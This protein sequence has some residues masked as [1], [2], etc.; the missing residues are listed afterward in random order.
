MLN[1]YSKTLWGRA[2]WW[3]KNWLSNFVSP[4]NWQ[5]VTLK[6]FWEH[7]Y[8]LDAESRELHRE[9]LELE[10]AIQNAKTTK[11]HLLYAQLAQNAADVRKRVQAEEHE[12]FSNLAIN[13]L[14]GEFD[15]E[16]FYIQSKD[17]RR[18]NAIDNY[19]R[20]IA[21]RVFSAFN[22]CCVFCR[23]TDDLTFDHYALSKNEGGNFVLIS[24]DKGSIRLNIVV[25]CRGCNAAKAQHGHLFYFNDEQRARAVSCQR[26]LLDILLGDEQFLKLVKKWGVVAERVG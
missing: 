20:N 21:D 4:G 11:K 14:Q 1:E 17:Y 24:A 15:R 3:R 18:G 26:A 5:D 12:K 19:F 25:L 2:P 23:S 8:S 10:R 16:D 6:S 9:Y 13:N 7:R 22:H